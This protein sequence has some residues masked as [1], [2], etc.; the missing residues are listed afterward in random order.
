MY[1]VKYA[2]VCEASKTLSVVEHLPME[3]TVGESPALPQG[4]Q[5]SESLDA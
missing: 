2:Q 3:E 1:A 5:Q 4:R